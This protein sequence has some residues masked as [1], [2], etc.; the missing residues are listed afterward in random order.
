MAKRTAL[1][2]DPAPAD[3][4]DPASGGRR[5]V[6]AIDGPASSGKSSVGAAAAERRGLR[7]VDTG[8]LYRAITALALREGVATDDAPGLSALVER[9]TLADDGSGRLTRVLMDGST[10]PTPPGRTMSMPP[11]PPWPW[12]PRFGPR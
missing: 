5:L 8:L 2:P 3:P 9:V 6:V 1:K 10:R 4:A 12:F 7:F 11:C